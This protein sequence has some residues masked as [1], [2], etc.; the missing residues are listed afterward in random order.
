[1]K[2]RRLWLVALCLVISICACLCLAACNNS[3]K[4]SGN[5]NDGNENDDNKNDITPL[6]APTVTIDSTG[7]AT[8]TEVTNASGYAFKID[9]GAEKPAE[10]RE[11]ALENGQ[12]VAVKAKGDG[13]SYSDSDFCAT[14]TY[15]APANRLAAP[16]NLTVAIQ[17]T[18]A[19]KVILN[20][21]AVEGASCYAYVVNGDE[22]NAVTVED[23]S[24]TVDLAAIDPSKLDSTWVF[25]VKALAADAK[26]IADDGDYSDNRVSS[27]YCEAVEFAV[28]DEIY[29]VAEIVKI[30]NY[31]GENLP[32][33]EFMITGT[34]GT[35]SDG[36]A[37][38][39]N[40][41]TLFGKSV[42]E[43][44][45]AIDDNL[46]G[47]D[48]TAIGMLTAKGG[49]KGLVVSSVDF[50]EVAEADRYAL[51]T[52]TLN[53]WD[54]LKEDSKIMSDFFLPV[55]LYGV[56]ILW[57][58][59]DEDTGAFAMDKYG[60]VTVTCP[61]DGAEDI[62]VILSALLYVDNAHMYDGVLEFKFA[63]SP[64]SRIELA[65]PK[66]SIDPKTG[67]ATW[68]EI[69]HAAGYFVTYYGFSIRDDYYSDYV[70]E[71]LTVAADGERSVQLKDGWWI[72]VKAL[73]DNAY[74]DSEV[75]SKQYNYYPETVEPDGTPLQFDLKKLTQTG[76][77]S[78]PNYIFGLACGNASVFESASATRVVL[79][80]DDVNGAV[81]GTGFIKVG[82]ANNNGKITLNF[83]KRILGVVITARQ[84]N[85]DQNDKVS[86]NG[87]AAQTASKNDWGVIYFNFTASKASTKVEIDVDNRVFIQSITVYVED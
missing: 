81:R 49:V 65:A 11:V 30:I 8:W 60:N 78:N 67:V 22:T 59:D 58:V 85:K 34:V 10:S 44:Y 52:E 16:E 3:N 69:E 83:N 12:S 9:G 19:G 72:T 6:T 84:W 87:S 25:R 32:S 38:L 42:P 82:S 71:E 54:M 86:V 36:N 47:F 13:V 51:V 57:D 63:I 1:M 66:I 79:G 55:R 15:K 26:E 41:L 46:V 37:V 80:N 7:K 76:E 39:E 31:Y 14:K 73:G 29:T 28:S 40:G 27:D 17:G 68:T 18:D 64:D 56:N 20:W 21:H 77:L 33:R 5:K 24:V 62:V 75:V 23:N 45:L 4:N 2:K 61:A 48:V 50:E 70:S 74:G 35:N 53:A 43:L